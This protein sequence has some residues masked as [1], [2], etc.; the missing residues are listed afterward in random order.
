M[1][2]YIGGVKRVQKSF[3]FGEKSLPDPDVEELQKHGIHIEF[4]ENAGHSMA[5]GN[6][7]GL[8]EAITRSI[9]KG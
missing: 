9:I 8:A 6:P 1:M 7:S 5:W 3:I 4:V 2:I